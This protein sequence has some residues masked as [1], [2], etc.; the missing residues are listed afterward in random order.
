VLRQFL[1]SEADSYVR[2][3]ADH[4]EWGATSYYRHVD[5]K[6]AD[7]TR[8]VTPSFGFDSKAEK[9]RRLKKLARLQAAL[10]RV[11]LEM[12]APRPERA[13][14]SPDAKGTLPQ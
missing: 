9:T 6:I 11:R 3:D 1:E 2:V 8:S 13:V 4:D 7:C 10:D 5:L 14:S 12:D